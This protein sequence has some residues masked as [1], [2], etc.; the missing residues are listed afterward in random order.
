VHHP[1]TDEKRIS[2]AGGSSFASGQNLIGVQWTLGVTEPGSS[3]SPLYDPQGRIIGQ[4]CCGGSFCQTPNNPDFYG[5]MFRNWTGGGTNGSRLSNWLDPIGTNQVTLDPI[6]PLGAAPPAND[7]C[8]NAQ[9]IN[10][11]NTTFNNTNATTSGPTVS[12][13]CV[14]GGDNQIQSDIWFSYTPSTSRVMRA[15]TCGSI[16]DTKLAVYDGCPGPSTAPLNCNDDADCNGDGQLDNASIVYFLAEAGNEY[17]FRV[18]GFNGDEGLGGIN[19]AQIAL[20][21]NNDC[22]NPLVVGEGITNFD[23]FG[24][25]PSGTATPCGIAAN[26]PDV[27]FSYVPDANGQAIISACNTAFTN[28]VAVYSGGCPGAGTLVGCDST[29]CNNRGV[30]L[31]DVVAGQEYLIRVASKQALADAGD[32]SITLIPDVVD[33]PACPGDINNDG[34]VNADDLSLLLSNFGCTSGCTAD[35]NDDG[36]VNADDLSVVL[37]AFGGSC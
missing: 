29:G 34:I 35:Q 23:A 15:R 19:L 12:G 11:G 21:A 18:G 14:V 8:V 27:W 6:G 28:G 10:L 33:P 22:S 17:I 16:F 32:L 31:L 20:P 5:R 26:A 37:S 7:L 3:G 24:A 9:P 2:F 25:A 13:L 1:N 30:V 4:L 36:V